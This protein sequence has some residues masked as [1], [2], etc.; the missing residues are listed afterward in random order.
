M[1][2]ILSELNIGK[3]KRNNL[4]VLYIVNIIQGVVIGFFNSVYQ[5][6]MLEILK[7]AFPQNAEFL[8]GVVQSTG[9]VCLIIT[10]YASSYLSDV[11]GKKTMILAGT[12]IFISGFIVLYFGLNIYLLIIGSM[13]VWGGFGT[14]DPSWVGSISQ[15]TEEK[16]SGLVYGLIFF[17]FSLG[18]IIGSFTVNR[19]IN[20]P[21]VSQLGFGFKHP[22]FFLMSAG[23]LLLEGAIQ[24]IFLN[25]NAVSKRTSRSEKKTQKKIWKV[26]LENPSLLKLLGFFMVDA[27]VWGI[28]FQ[29]YYTSLLSI[30][31][32][33][34]IKTSDLALYVVMV[35]NIGNLLLQIPSGWLVD[36]IG[37]KKSFLISSTFGVV[38][39][40]LN[41]IMWFT[42]R[43]DPISILIIT[44][45]S[46]TVLVVTFMPA[47]NK[48]ISSVYPKRTT[49]IYGFMNFARNILWFISGYLAGWILNSFGFIGP[50]I[51]GLVGVI[52]EI[53][54]LFLV[55]DEK[56]LIASSTAV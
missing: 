23:G 18:S 20:H 19:T 48:I 36:K 9:F 35:V 54:Y 42:S 6:H 17:F 37:A 32:G 11:F 33:I 22:F 2:Q 15:N 13:L 1:S 4:I 53:T 50:M 55:V 10:M 21:I 34:G 46:W 30:D 3:I 56:K 47:Q 39:I 29:L 14:V 16:R 38:F 5:A 25:E 26:Y 8:V 7:E 40:A 52:G 51:F 45:I 24:A 43:T 41:M 49:E 12:L 44:S 28:C 27:F 31:N